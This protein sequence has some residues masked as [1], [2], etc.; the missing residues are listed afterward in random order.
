MKIPEDPFIRELLPEFVD[1]WMQDITNQYSIFI[2]EKNGAELYR[3]AHTIKGSCFQFGLD[4]IAE[5]GITIM[6]YAKAEDFESAAPME[7]K[8]IDSFSNVKKFIAE[9]NIS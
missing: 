2:K 4:E 6:G 5:M 1:T 3:L 7:K 8:L 9:N